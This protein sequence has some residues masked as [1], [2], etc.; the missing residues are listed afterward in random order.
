MKTE[1]YTDKFPRKPSTEQEWRQFFEFWYKPILRAAL[2]YKSNLAWAEEAT[3]EVFLNLINIFNNPKA[4]Q[5]DNLFNWIYGV[6]FKTFQVQSRKDSK[7]KRM[8]NIDAQE[9]IDQIISEDPDRLCEEDIQLRIFKTIKKLNETESNI[10]KYFFWEG[11]QVSEIAKKMKTSAPHISRL[12]YT[13]LRTI[14]DE[15]EPARN[16]LG[17]FA[18]PRTENT[19]P[20]HNPREE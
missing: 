9:I 13:A 3:S 15:L 10:L 2:R 16:E 20:E 6:A 11:L 18:G 12:K 1:Q 5:I 14:Q 19:G 17:N 8:V 7:H 4:V